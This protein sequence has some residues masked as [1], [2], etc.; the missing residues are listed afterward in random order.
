MLIAVWA[1]TGREYFW[2]VWPILGFTIAIIW[3]AFAVWG[4]RPD[5]DHDR[6]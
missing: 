4:P 3:Q 5:D 2:P 6:P 1:L